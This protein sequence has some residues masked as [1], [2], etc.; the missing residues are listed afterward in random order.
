MNNT[1]AS[2]N[3]VGATKQPV[4]LTGK[5]VDYMKTVAGGGYVTLGVKGGGCSGLTYVWGQTDTREH[6][7]IK[8]SEPVEGILLLDPMSEIYVMGS[9]ID[10]IE[11]LGGSYLTIR[12]PMQSSS[13]G[14]GSSFSV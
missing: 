12:N 4:S 10:Y 14:C 1:A 3:M 2:L 8:W 9:E 7:R 13:C 5:A 11:E 6:E